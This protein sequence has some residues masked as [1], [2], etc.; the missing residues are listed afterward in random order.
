ML[1]A[2]YR[3]PFHEKQLAETIPIEHMNEIRH[4]VVYKGLEASVQV[5]LIVIVLRVDTK[6]IETLGRRKLA[7]L[8]QFE[9]KLLSGKDPRTYHFYIHFTDGSYLKSL[10]QKRV[11]GREHGE[12]S[13]YYNTGLPFKFTSAFISIP[14]G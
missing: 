11:K 12:S 5:A 10:D 2:P 4:C 7:Y 3:K 9:K 13:P 1:Q 14:R 6:T 8:C